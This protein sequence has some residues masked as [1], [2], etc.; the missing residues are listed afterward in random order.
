MHVWANTFDGSAWGQP[1]RID[2]GYASSAQHA[3]RMAIDE[4]GNALAVWRQTDSS[5]FNRV[6]SN[7]FAAGTGWGAI[8][9]PISPA[10]VHGIEPR[11]AV[12]RHGNAVAVWLSVT[13]EAATFLVANHFDVAALA[14][15]TEVSVLADDEVDQLAPDL[16][17]DAAGNA[18]VI[19][20]VEKSEAAALVTAAKRYVAHKASWEATTELSRSIDIVSTPPM[21]AIDRQ[22]DG[23]ALFVQ[24]DLDFLNEHLMTVPF[25]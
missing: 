22:G 6:V 25:K 12:D 8:A 18:L 23:W 24:F 11:I 19:F 3:P 9:A 14:W 7:R 17:V 1:A 21:L 13:P 2:M 5:A 4:D 10:A 15:D 16:V 20:H